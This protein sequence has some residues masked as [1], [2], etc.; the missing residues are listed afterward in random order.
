MVHLILMQTI[1]M[2][3]GGVT[4]RVLFWSSDSVVRFL[5]LA[6]M[7]ELDWTEFWKTLI[8]GR[9]VIVTIVD[10]PLRNWEGEYCY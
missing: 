4:S 8:K 3:K 5:L 2:I 7:I 10:K 6:L 9:P 1:F